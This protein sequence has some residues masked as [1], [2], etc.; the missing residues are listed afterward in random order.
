MAERCPTCGIMPHHNIQ[1]ALRRK[2]AT[3]G[4]DW[5]VIRTSA[6]RSF[7]HK[8]RR[9]HPEYEWRATRETFHGGDAGRWTIEARRV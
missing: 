6:S 1:T 4:T 2:I 8:L 9:R 3:V 7:V 5:A